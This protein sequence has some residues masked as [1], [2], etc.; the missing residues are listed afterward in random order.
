MPLKKNRGLIVGFDPGLTAGIAILD[1][2]GNILSVT[3]FK[4]IT[5]AEIIKHIISY[6]KAV[7]ISTDVYP[8]PK[9][10][11]KLATSLNAKLHYPFKD[12]SVG[13]KIELVESHL[14][15]KYSSRSKVVPSDEVPQDAHQRD[16]L[17][18]SIRTYKSYEKKMEII[19]TRSKEINLTS[20]Q[21]EQVKMMV[22]DGTAISSAI[23]MI[24]E[25][26]T[27]TEEDNKSK[28]LNEPSDLNKDSDLDET[29]LKLKNRIKMQDNQILYLKNKNNTLEEEITHYQDEIS[30]LQDKIDK[31]HYE[32][33]H[34]ILFKKEITAK[35]SLI[36]K[37]QDK[38]N[39]EKTLR[40]NLEDNLRSLQNIQM[41]NPTHNSIPV[42]IIETFTREGI[43]KA[44]DYW[45]IK[46][47]DVVLLKSSE[48]G[49]SQT[50]AHLIRMGVKAVLIQDKI[51]HQAQEE[52][53]K[54]MVPL[55][56]ADEMD[57]K[58][59]DQ[60]AIVNS[61]NLEEE[62]KKWREH[63]ENKMIKESNQEILKVIDEYRARRKRSV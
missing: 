62:I 25:M 52:F 18:A 22:I 63:T 43:R 2:K 48:G 16:A 17:A 54:N 1:L 31:L 9:M 30:K 40:C 57:L 60:F 29:F 6:G 34:D 14:S 26:N 61:L 7:L 58:M 50:A 28:S 59:I 56:R 41:I 37:L 45:K 10:V 33:T 38:Y 12:M 5:R 24:M 11:K 49:G 32:Y 4:E 8:P 39:E 19:E 20:Q 42:K 44:C 21:I 51:S 15:E 47:D 55:L 3:S 23:R 13:S 53:E 27:Q 46:R 35:I 36:K